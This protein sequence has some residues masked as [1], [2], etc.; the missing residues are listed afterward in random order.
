MKLEIQA[1]DIQIMK[2]VFACRVVSYSQIIRRH[3]PKTHEVVAR[4]RI[5]GL[6]ECGYFK[7]SALELSGKVVRI[8]QPLPDLWPLIQQKWPLEVDSPHFKSESLEHDV[9]MAEM[10]IRFE[11]LKCFRSFFTENLLQSSSALAEDPRFRDLAKIQ[12]DGALTI[13]D[14]KGNLR[15]FGVE[16]ELSKKSPDGYRQKLIDYYLAKGIDGV[17]YVSPSR[18]IHTLL[19]RMEEEVGKDRE[20]L[21]WRTY[22][23]NTLGD[24][25][26]I[27]FHNRKEQ[28]LELR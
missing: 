22:E 13:E 4:R 25:T 14:S 16:F 19:T 3:F 28:S 7:I 15:I 21:V 20:P 27:I 12:S 1:R 6:A 11:K 2:F 17:F 8:V 10:F 5:R 24:S 9:R 26:K 18:Q 23:E